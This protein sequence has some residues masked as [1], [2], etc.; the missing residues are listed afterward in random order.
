MNLDDLAAMLGKTIM[1]TPPPQVGLSQQL[2]TESANEDQQ[3]MQLQPPGSSD[4]FNRTDPSEGSADNMATSNSWPVAGSSQPTDDYSNMAA[5]MA[6][7]MQLMKGKIP[8][9]DAVNA[10]P[11]ADLRYSPQ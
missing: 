5:H 8:I 6:I 7:L 10:P 3:L 4:V 9:N 2:P 1:T 11:G